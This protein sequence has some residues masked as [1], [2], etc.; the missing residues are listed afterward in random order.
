MFHGLL[1]GQLQ[2]TSAQPSLPLVSLWRAVPRQ[3]AAQIGFS[4]TEVVF[5]KGPEEKYCRL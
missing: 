3:N 2:L 5:S 1:L 4:Q